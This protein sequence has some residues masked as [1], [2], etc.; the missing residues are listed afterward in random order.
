MSYRPSASEPFI[1]KSDRPS[2]QEGRPQRIVVIEK[3]T[4]VVI[5]RSPPRKRAEPNGP[6]RRM[7]PRRQSRDYSGFSLTDLR[8][9]AKNKQIRGY[10]RATRSEL[11]LM[12]Q[13]N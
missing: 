11:I 13:T 2:R 4:K 1:I 6:P 3:P 5:K 12:L 10:S 9:M 7:S 8:N